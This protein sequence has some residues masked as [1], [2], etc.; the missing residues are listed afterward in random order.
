MT[1][2]IDQN[3][4]RALPLHWELRRLKEIADVIP[5]NVDKLTVE[6]QPPV[7]LCN[8][9]DTY[10]HDRITSVIEFMKAS[11]TLAQIERL[12]LSKGDLTIT[13]DSESPW[14]IAV[15]AYVAEY[16]EG[17]VCGYH[18]AK[19][20]PDPKRVDGG[21][22][23]WALRS[24]PVNLQFAL[25]AQGI[26][27]YGLSA[28]A[29]AGGRVPCPP[30][31]EQIEI[32]A[33]LDVET[34]RIDELVAEKRRL[35]AALGHLKTTRISELLTGANAGEVMVDTGDLW[36]PQLPEGWSLKRLKQIGQVRS[37]LAKGKKHETAV[38]TIELPYM[39]VA[40]VQDGHLDLSDVA[41]IE[42]ALQ[43]VER[44]TLQVGDVLMNEGG[45]YDKLGRGAVWEGAVES[46]LHQNHVFAV[47]LDDVA[48]AP[49]VAAI[50]RTAYAK[51][52]FMNNSKQST[53]LAS[54]SQTNVKELPVAMPPASKRDALLHTLNDELRR[55][56][57]LVAHVQQEL[58]LLAELRAAT[59]TDAVLGRIDVRSRA[60]HTPAKEAPA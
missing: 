41:L 22:L 39:R 4:R 37:G 53:N 60:D 24:K 54:I 35:L 34:A 2:S 57:A 7:Q 56:D 59:I 58:G 21:F 30:V 16:V 10:K 55:I 36:L 11:A 42:V 40:N 32:A 46:C 26:T 14:D 17:L 38:T 23:A 33:Y 12:S 15:P 1:F 28:G 9:V 47:R 43:D 52:Y 45:D 25:S 18:L 31:S 6:G 44:Y 48:W 8:Y 19:I 3:L 49:W 5:S 50:T 13:K 29:L 20:S 27:R 51:F